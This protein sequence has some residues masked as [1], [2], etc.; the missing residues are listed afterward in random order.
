MKTL[1]SSIFICCI[2]LCG[3]WAQQ[4]PLIPFP[5]EIISVGA[6]EFTL[7]SATKIVLRTNVAEVKKS[8]DFFLE[9][10]N[11]STGL[12]I[13]YAASSTSPIIVEL[14]ATVSH[15]EGY[16]LKV[17]SKDVTIKAQTAT[18]VFFALQTLRQLLPPEIES[19][20]AV[21]G[22]TWKIPEVEINDAPRFAYRGLLLDVARHFYPVSDI[23]RYIDLM[24]LHKF[25]HLQLHLADDQGW[26]IEIK[27]YPK[28]NSISS[29]RKETLIGHLDNLPHKY[30]GIPHGGY[31]TQTEL[32]E[33]VQYAADR[34]ITIVPEIDMP[35]HATAI[36]AAYPEFACIDSTFEVAGYWG[37]LPNVLCPRE[38]TFKFLENIMD[39][40]MSIFPGKYIHIGGDECP[41][42]QWKRSEICNNLLKQNGYENY[43]QLQTWF[44]RRMVQYLQSHGRQVIGWDEIIDGG[45]IDGATIMS[46]RG[47]QGGITAAQKGNNVIMTPHRYCY[48]DYYQWRMRDE[49]PL[50][51]GGY[52]PL[53]MVYQYDPVPKELNDEQKKRILGSQGNLWTEYISDFKYVEYMVYPRACAIAEITWTPANKKSYNQFLIR[54]REY[55]KRLEILNV[56]FARHML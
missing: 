2:G 34:H 19:R 12:N 23:K 27:Q 8:C 7:T 30:D 46:W 22:Q 24:V 21:A 50:A 9:L 52:L 26:R 14:D 32:K 33:L 36:L 53:S 37:I 44:M 5:T 48:I 31:Y 6:G 51:Q 43:D 18:G 4:L 55:S 25:N 56:N 17:T 45:T 3:V 29:W 40:V 11:P 39:E 28:L 1:F 49:E 16:S 15:P 54:L 10:I 20:S 42:E 35:G 47:E 13:G 41:R 38:E